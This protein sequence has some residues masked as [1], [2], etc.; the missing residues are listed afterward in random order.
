MK[1]T[2]SV[3][4][5]RL[6]GHME[7]HARGFMCVNKFTKG[8]QYAR[9]LFVH[10]AMV[11]ISHSKVTHVN[12]TPSNLVKNYIILKRNYAYSLKKKEDWKED[13]KYTIMEEVSKKLEGTSAIH[14]LQPDCRKNIMAAQLW[15]S[16]L[17]FGKRIP[18]TYNWKRKE[19]QHVVER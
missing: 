7:M 5:R 16:F 3:K 13:P 1:S 8:Y 4:Y 9:W 17:K 10:L 12:V 6:R 18:V 14:N 2:L 11:L 19:F 15:K